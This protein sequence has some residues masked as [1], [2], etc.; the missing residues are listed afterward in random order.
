MALTPNSGINIGAGAIRTSISSVESG[1][2]MIPHVPGSDANRGGLRGDNLDGANALS[3]VGRDPTTTADIHDLAGTVKGHVE[4]ALTNPFNGLSE[5]LS[6]PPN[7]VSGAGGAG[8]APKSSGGPGA[9][10]T[11]STNPNN[12]GLSPAQMAALNNANKL[13]PLTL[14]SMLADKTNDTA[15]RRNPDLTEQGHPTADPQLNEALKELGTQLSQNLD[16]FKSDLSKALEGITNKQQFQQEF[17][18]SGFDDKKEL[19]SFLDEMNKDIKGAINNETGELENY[20]KFSQEKLDRFNQFL[21]SAQENGTY[22]DLVSQGRDIADRYQKGVDMKDNDWV[23][24]NF[25]TTTNDLQAKDGSLDKF[26]AANTSVAAKEFKNDAQAAVDKAQEMFSDP[27]VGAKKMQE[28]MDGDF[29]KAIT[30]LRENY[31][32]EGKPLEGNEQAQE[33]LDNMMFMKFT[34]PHAEHASDLQGVIEDVVDKAGERPLDVED[35]RENDKVVDFLDKYYKDEDIS[36][37]QIELM[38]KAASNG[39]NTA[40]NQL[41]GRGQTVYYDD[42]PSTPE[43]SVSNLTDS[44]SFDDNSDIDENIQDDIQ[45][46]INEDVQEQQAEQEAQEIIIEEEDFE[47]DEDY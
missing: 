19:M 29:D 21:D 4:N 7:G 36:E 10:K 2:T 28:Y 26:A 47:L 37:Q 22:N 9:Q 12:G 5:S 11:T 27:D 39:E 35:F 16:N 3:P 42:M 40:S 14:S 41:V 32:A 33:I 25:I 44:I 45:A 20:G 38:F 46:N 34:S 13:D 8:G 1:R 24:G 43:E 31:L 30:D 18:N 17:Q 23:S 15:Q 6:G